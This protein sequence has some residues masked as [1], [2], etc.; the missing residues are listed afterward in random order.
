[1]NLGGSKLSLELMMWLFTAVLVVLIL[2]PIHFNI[3]A[4]PFYF[5]NVLFIV[6]FITFARYIFLLKHTY[7][8]HSLIFKVVMMVAAIPIIM[9]LLDSVSV[10]QGFTDDVGLDTLVPELTIPRQKAIMRYVRTEMIFFGVGAVIVAFI[11]P[12]RMLIS[13]W[14]GINKNTV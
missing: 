2:M 9:Y 4:Y 12:F 8:A 10:F 13:I 7:V 3:E 11:F 14:R 6:V 5:S 1:M